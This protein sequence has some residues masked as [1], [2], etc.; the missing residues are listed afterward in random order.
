MKTEI[1]LMMLVV[2]VFTLGFFSANVFN[3]LVDYYDV[4]V[5]F[6]DDL[7][8]YNN[9]NEK[10]PSDSINQNQIKVLKDKVIIHIDDAS[11]SHYASTGSMKPVLDENSNG[12]RISVESVDDINEGDIVSFKKDN[13]LIVHRVIKKGVDGEGV[14]FITK[15]DNNSIDDGKI[16]FDQI[17][18]KTIG[19]IW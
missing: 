4:E 17:D 3:S 16:R 13:M 8:I 19:V 12:I 11:L 1:I 5:P 15:G 18:Y 6:L 2:C 14:Y 7:G 10:T 9:L